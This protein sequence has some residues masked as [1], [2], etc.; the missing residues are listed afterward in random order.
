M[1]CGNHEEFPYL[2]ISADKIEERSYIDYG[3]TNF[4]HLGNSLLTVFLII[5]S[6]TWYT[7]LMNMLDVDIPLIG[8]VFC[9]L[10][11]I[12][13]QFFLM[14]LILAV[15]IFAFIKTSK[16]DLEGDFKNFN[17]NGE[18]NL[19]DDEILSHS[20]NSNPFDG[21]HSPSSPT[22]KPEDGGE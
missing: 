11:L 20:L 6:D 19:P 3:I 18:E 21:S 4:D 14:N 1:Y 16:R 10:M 12:I 22:K 5:N 13:G 2:D 7:K 8:Y 9:V 15:I 17:K